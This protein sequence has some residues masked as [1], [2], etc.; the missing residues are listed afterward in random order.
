MLILHGNWTEGGLR[1]WGESLARC[2]AGVQ[3]GAPAGP[4]D[5][6]DADHPFAATIEELK[7]ALR[8]AAGRGRERMRSVVGVAAGSDE[9][10]DTVFTLPLPIVDGMPAPSERLIGLIADPPSGPSRPGRVRVPA[11]SIPATTAPALLPELE[12]SGAGEVRIAHSL[13]WFR[14]V[15]RFT[16]S[17]VSDQRFLPSLYRDDDLGLEATWQPWLLDDAARATLALLLDSMPPVVR[18][19]PQRAAGRPWP[20]LDE[21]LRTWTDARIRAVLIR[22]RFDDVLEGRDPDADPHVAWLTGLLSAPRPV[23]I[24]EAGRARLFSAVARWLD[25]L[26]T[27]GR[28]GEV[29]L[30]LRLVEPEEGESPWRLEFGLVGAGAGGPDDDAGPAFVS[31]QALW[32]DPASAADLLGRSGTGLEERLLAEIGRAA[33]IH[34][35]LETALSAAQ[36][37]HL[38]LSTESA[39]AFLVEGRPVLLESGVH[40]E[41][42]PWWG[43]AS[44]GLSVRL[45]IHAPSGA[46]EIGA[47]GTAPSSGDERTAGAGDRGAAVA[48]LAS[49]VE[50]HWELAVGDRSL[51]VE[52]FRDLARRA[53]GGA[54]LLRLRDRWVEVRPEEIREAGTLLDERPGGEMPLL[55]ALRI[56][57]GAGGGGVTLPVHGVTASG[58]VRTLLD[59]TDDERLATTEAPPSFVGSLRPYQLQGLAWLRF[60]DRHGLGACLADDMGLGKTIQLIAL[61]LAEREAGLPPPA[62]PTLVVSP[63]SVIVNWQREL[64]RFAPGL[65]VLVHHGPDRP[66]GAALVESVL[67]SD[68]VLTTYSIVPRDRESLSVPAWHRIVLDE[69]QYIKNTP[70]KQT[71]AI[72]Q[73]RTDRRIALTGT[74]VENRLSELWSIIDFLNPGYLGSAAEFRRRFAGPIERQRDARASARLRRLVRPFVLRRLKTDPKVIDDLPSCVRTKEYAN[75]SPEQAVLYERTVRE[76]L[77]EVGAAEGIRRRGLVLATLGRLKQICNHPVLSTMEPGDDA[78]GLIGDAAGMSQLVHRSG[79]C[80]RMLELLDEVVASGGHALVFTQFRRMGHLLTAMIEHAL[81]AEVLFLHGGTPTARRQQIV[82]R[83]Q[84]QSSEVPVLVLS[85][86]AGGV[87]LNLTAANHVFHFDRWWN[88]AVE[89]QA[90]DRAFRIGQT[91]AVQ[92]HSFICTGTLEE[93]IDQMIERKTHLAESIVGA[94]EEWLTELSTGQLRDLL[95]LRDEATEGDDDGTGDGGD[96]LAARG[97]LACEEAGT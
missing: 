38:E 15:A 31:A 96:G 90:T 35:P 32:R 83:F 53:A 71:A 66:A 65:R 63:T 58:W 92:V 62:G 52:E 72:R 36:P 47:T 54:A 24:A 41:V 68:V 28:Q 78:S 85:L 95:M 67:R 61:L 64:A 51:D 1:L 46:D 73:L 87:G 16:I 42:P 8:I 55:E 50:Y 10:G 26:D 79:K 49:I 9:P 34:A 2:I 25:G 12:D 5:G 4:V 88:P 7:I 17:L 45:V 14:E 89:N 77:A 40:V 60:L 22:E 84:E 29:R 21:I 91:R 76:M 94:G 11:L 18:G 44:A 70:A 59:A 13:R 82:D 81:G 33:R 39:Y 75:L 30:S 48:G 97:A 19:T 86:R 80:R 27:A 74:P 37:T 3:R 93:R 43:E 56:A 57:G 23:P 69:A 6:P 20:I